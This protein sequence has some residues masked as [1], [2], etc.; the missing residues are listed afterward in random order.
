MSDV[1]NNTKWIG[2]FQSLQAEQRLTVHVTVEGSV[3]LTNTTTG[4]SWEIDP[5]TALLIAK[6][7]AEG[8]ETR[9]LIRHK[10]R[11]IEELERQLLK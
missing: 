4:V 9:R 11:E 8:A 5:G 6:T 7:L 2:A 1:R 10:L 3:A